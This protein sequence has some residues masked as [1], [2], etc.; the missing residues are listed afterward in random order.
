MKINKELTLPVTLIPKETIVSEAQKIKTGTFFTIGYLRY[1]KTSAAYT[2]GAHVNKLTG[3]TY[4]KVSVLKCIEERGAIGK[5]YANLKGV[6]ERN[7]DPD[8]AA[9]QAEKQ[10]KIDKMREE[11]PDFVIPPK[12]SNWEVKGIIGTSSAGNEVLVFYPNYVNNTR[13][14]RA[15]EYYISIDGEPYRKVPLE[16]LEPYL[17]ASTYNEEVNPRDT[18]NTDSVIGTDEE[19][20][21]KKEYKINYRL[22]MVKQLYKFRDEG[23]MHMLAPSKKKV[24]TEGYEDDLGEPYSKDRVE[25]EL[26]FITFGFEK[27]GSVKCYYDEEK[28]SAIEI[29]KKHYKTVNC[30]EPDPNGWMTI[31]FTKE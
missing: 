17:T 22:Y 23:E 26:K 7:A 24:T 18:I 10:A 14:K 21:A 3:E 13:D 6:K 9:K 4:P 20:G 27:N 28:E 8:Y 31:T 25:K 1:V 11:D 5:T 19:T 2:D 15:I 30:S 12:I 29:L 16:E